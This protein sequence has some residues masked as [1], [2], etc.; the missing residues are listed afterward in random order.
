[1]YIYIPGQCTAFSPSIKGGEEKE[2][3]NA[4]IIS[5][6]I[7]VLNGIAIS[8]TDENWKPLRNGC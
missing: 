1:M 2:L 4:K 7:C 8:S 5:S 6:S 3:W